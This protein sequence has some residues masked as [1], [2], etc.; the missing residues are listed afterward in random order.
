MHS[1]NQRLMRRSLPSKYNDDVV[2]PLEQ[3]VARE[4]R[5]EQEPTAHNQSPQLFM[6][7]DEMASSLHYPFMDNDLALDNTFCADLLHPS[8]NLGNCNSTNPTLRTNGIMKLH[9][10]MTSEMG[11][12]LPSIPLA[13]RMELAKSKVQNFMHFSRH[14]AKVAR[15][16]GLDQNALVSSR[17]VAVVRESTGPGVDIGIAMQGL[18]P[19]LKFFFKKNLV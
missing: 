8:N 17:S 11:T 12:S 7:E 6:Q 3:S 4:I 2:I 18:A 13:R 19:L 14:K 1:Q 16:E 10:A 9:Q 15:G 5:S